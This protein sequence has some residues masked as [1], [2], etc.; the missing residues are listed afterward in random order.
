MG[1]GEGQSLS[2]SRKSKYMTK[3]KKSLPHT[4]PCDSGLFSLPPPPSL[5]QFVIKEGK[6][7]TLWNKWLCLKGKTTGWCLWEDPDWDTV[8]RQRGCLL[9]A[10]FDHY[11]T[12]QGNLGPWTLSLSAGLW[13]QELGSL[14]VPYA[15]FIWWLSWVEWTLGRDAFIFSYL[16]SLLIFTLG[17]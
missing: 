1:V 14:I 8:E 9:G 6:M 12:R 2:G 3:K 17:A 10:A 11:W 15:G 16:T 7:A 5:S 13:K 4:Y